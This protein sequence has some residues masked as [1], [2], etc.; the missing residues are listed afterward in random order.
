MS[1]RGAHTLLSART[2]LFKGPAVSPALTRSLTRSWPCGSGC[3]LAIAGFG[4]L[5][6]DIFKHIKA[7][8]CLHVPAIAIAEA[9]GAAAQN[10]LPQQRHRQPAG[11]CDL[12][13]SWRRDPR[14]AGRA[15]AAVSAGPRHPAPAKVHPPKLPIRVR[16]ASVSGAARAELSGC[17]IDLRQTNQRGDQPIPDRSS[18]LVYT[19]R[20]MHWSGSNFDRLSSKLHSGTDSPPRQRRLIDTK[21]RSVYWQVANSPPRSTERILALCRWLSCLRCRA[22]HQLHRLLRCHTAT[23][24]VPRSTYEGC[25]FC[26]HMSSDPVQT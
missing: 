12:L 21:I 26:W 3:Y 19:P 20:R 5:N 25:C 22:C 17:Q 23:N 15:G 7:Y 6:F 10:C 11:A 18:A 1:A 14:G 2:S 13:C 16:M 24:T 4:S 8:T 9:A